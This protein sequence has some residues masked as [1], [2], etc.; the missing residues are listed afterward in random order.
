[1]VFNIGGIGKLRTILHEH[2]LRVGGF[3]MNLTDEADQ[4]LPRLAMRAGVF[5]GIDGGELPFVVAGKR[6]DGLRQIRDERFELFRGALRSAGLP[7]IGAKVQVFHAKTVAFADGRIEIFRPRKVVH[8]R[9]RTGERGFVFRRQGNIGAIEVGEFRGGKRQGSDRGNRPGNPAVK[10]LFLSDF[11]RG[12]GG[13]PM[14]PGKR[15]IAIFIGAGFGELIAQLFEFFHQIVALGFELFRFQLQ[16]TRVG[17]GE[18]FRDRADGA[19]Q[20]FAAVQVAF[21]DADAQRAKLGDNVMANHAQRFGRVAGDQNAFSL[22][23]QVANQ[24]SDGV[25]LARAG[26]TL[27]EDTSVLFELAG[28]ANLFGVGG[29]TKQDFNAVL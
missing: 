14:F 5:S 23:Q 16:S 1:M 22:R 18:P 7:K 13:R 24:V 10:F 11:A 25:G 4:L 26:R 17:A 29:L 8:F 6:V 9:K 2:F 28:D 12:V 3:L 19:F 15:N 27:N 21:E 20:L